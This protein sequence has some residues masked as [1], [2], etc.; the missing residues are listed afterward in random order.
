MWLHLWDDWKREAEASLSALERFDPFYFAK[1][2]PSPF[3]WRAVP[4]FS[5]RTIFLDVETD[6]TDKIT[7]IG[8]D[9]KNQFR[10]FVR[11][12]DDFDEARQWLERAGMVVTYNGKRFDIPVLK[13]NFPDWQIPPLH[14]DLCPLLRRLG[15]KGGLKGVEAQLGIERSPQ[16]QGLNGWDAVRLWW[17]WRDYGDENSLELLLQYNREDVVNLKPLLEFAYQRLWQLACE[18]AKLPLL[19]LTNCNERAIT[20]VRG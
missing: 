15:Y 14:I 6:G 10:A 2:L 8:I 16:T 7:V 18:G 1:K 19:D 3:W 13:S 20:D 5:D 4:E 11:G 17:M 12:I 9:E